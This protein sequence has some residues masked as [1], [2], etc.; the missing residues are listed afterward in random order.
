[1]SVF[2]TG[3]SNLLPFAVVFDSDSNSSTVIDRCYRPIIA[4]PGKWPGC[5]MEL[6]TVCDGAPMFGAKLCAQFYAEH[7]QPA[8]DPAVRRRIRAL[9]NGCAALKA[10]L[11]RRSD[12]MDA[13][14][15]PPHDKV[16]SHADLI[17]HTF[18]EGAAA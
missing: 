16:R 11:R 8:R 4:A 9:V 17:H 5:T 13:A 18:S 7:A 1:M 3:K 2:R 6:A 10:E 14:D 15:E 12:A